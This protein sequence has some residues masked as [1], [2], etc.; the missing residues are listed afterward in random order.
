[1]PSV[2][3]LFSRESEG[4]EIAQRPGGEP[5]AAGLVAR[6]GR[7]VD[8]YDRAPVAAG[9]ERGRDAARTGPDDHDVDRAAPSPRR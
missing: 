7:L 3:E 4:F 6:E 1:M 8:A 2:E 5:V 9:R